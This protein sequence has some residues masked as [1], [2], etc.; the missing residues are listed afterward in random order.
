MNVTTIR[1]GFLNPARAEYKTFRKAILNL[2]VTTKKN[3][4]I[5]KSNKFRSGVQ[6]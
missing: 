2:S 5:L 1:A 4:S 3:W 6:E